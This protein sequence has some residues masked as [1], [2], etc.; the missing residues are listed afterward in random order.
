[1]IYL[2]LCYSESKLTRFLR[3]SLGGSTKTR[4]IATISPAESSTE[5]TIGTL[6]YASQAKDIRNKPEVNQ[7]V[8]NE[9]LL[10]ERE[11]RIK[12]LEEEM[13]KILRKEGIHLTAE[14]YDQYRE[15][16]KTHEQLKEQYN[17]TLNEFEEHKELHAQTLNELE[18]CNTRLTDMQRQLEE[19]DR[20]I[21]SVQA[22]L[23]LVKQNLAEQKVLTEAH[24]ATE[25]C[26]DKAARGLKDTLKVVVNDVDSLHA[27]VDRK[28]RVEEHNHRVIQS[29]ASNID[30]HVSDVE[31]LVARIHGMHTENTNE[32]RD[33]TRS[34][35]EQRCKVRRW[36]TVHVERAF[37][38]VCI[39]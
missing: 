13:E 38:V 18:E 10:K 5:E 36:M 29:L 35:L 6:E 21:A 24:A 30:K 33:N 3:D 25:E 2:T 32:L 23:R 4:I 15:L 17:Q 34:F 1:M 31:S 28:A 7:L 12:H 9:S 14:E 19:K 39:F 26:I 16:A 11:T 8:D 27:K 20:L 37:I 22:N